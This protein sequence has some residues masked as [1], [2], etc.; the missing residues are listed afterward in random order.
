MGFAGVTAPIS[1]LRRRM[2][3]QALR[4]SPR[5]P[6]IN[7]LNPSK[8]CN[9]PVANFACCAGAIALF[10][11]ITPA[12]L[13]SCWDAATPFARRSCRQR[14]SGRGHWGKKGPSYEEARNTI[15]GQGVTVRSANRYFRIASGLILRGTGYSSSSMDRCWGF[16]GFRGA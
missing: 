2:L 11:I 5:R 6:K 14:C 13:P 8:Q 15:S 12:T 1:R 3:A 16:R 7:K 10:I 9:F 4:L